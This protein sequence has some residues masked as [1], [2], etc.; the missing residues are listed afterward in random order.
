MPKAMISA[1]ADDERPGPRRRAGDRPGDRDDRRVRAR[2]RPSRRARSWSAGSSSGC[3]E[4][5]GLLELV[6]PQVGAGGVAAAGAAGSVASE[7]PRVGAAGVQPGRLRI[8]RLIVGSGGLDQRRRR[9]SPSPSTRDRRCTVASESQA[10]MSAVRPYA[11]KMS[12]SACGAERLRTGQLIEDRAVDQR[13]TGLRPRPRSTAVSAVGPWKTVRWAMPAPIIT[14]A[15]TNAAT[16]HTKRTNEH[17]PGPPDGAARTLDSTFQTSENDL[18]DA[19]EG[20]IP[21]AG[22]HQCVS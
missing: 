1:A 6:E 16:A 13:C 2:R 9:S 8:R 5:V 22:R 10:S 18:K 15:S 11:A 7:S 19:R 20:S 14:A 4:D 12:P 17:L 21:G 3:D